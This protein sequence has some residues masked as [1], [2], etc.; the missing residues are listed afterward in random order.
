MRAHLARLGSVAAVIGALAL[1]L[2]SMLAALLAQTHQPAVIELRDV[3]GHVGDIVTVCGRVT[4][5]HC[6]RPKRTTYLDLEAPYWDGG[7][8]VAIAADKR[9][10]FGIRIEDRY[11]F[12]QVCATG[13]VEQ[14][15]KR[16]LVTVS[17][18]EKLRIEAEPESSPVFLEPLG[19]RAC[20]EGVELPQPVSRVNPEYPSGARA[21]RREAIVLL[22]GVV[23]TD[24]SVGDV[25]VV[26]AP[27]SE[28]EFD[29]A[30]V[31]AFKEWRFTP[32]TMRGKPVPVIV[33]VQLTF[34]LR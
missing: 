29:A 13:R 28:S 31:K 33:G 18:P 11:I 9:Q 6:R 2:G 27:G 14:E 8:S 16:Y 10:S 34:N 32:G 5:H 12:R 3:R 15:R 24:G 26:H 30:A 19:V 22:D 7:V 17:Q 4:T 21:N 25:V 23:Q 20:D 1:P